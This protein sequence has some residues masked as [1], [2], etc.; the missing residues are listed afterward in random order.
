MR[1]F[2]IVRTEALTL[3]LNT[4]GRELASYGDLSY[5]DFSFN[6]FECEWQRKSWEI[7]GDE[8]HVPHFCS[9]GDWGCNITDVL[10]DSRLDNLSF[11]VEPEQSFL[12]RYYT[13]FMLL[14]VEMINDFVDILLLAELS[15]GTKTDRKNS[16][17]HAIADVNE[18]TNLINSL[19][20]HK[21]DKADGGHIHFHNH[22]LP[23]WFEDC[24]LA[25][26]FKAPIS[27]DKA[28][29]SAPDGIIVPSLVMLTQVI[30]DGYQ[31]IDTHFEADANRFTAFCKRH[32]KNYVD[33]V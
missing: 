23:V 29:Q 28:I 33:P 11:G 14:T 27:Q 16:L 30:I 20:K 19:C 9:L 3:W 17:S 18:L 25:H 10:L 22:H 8:W 1:P 6:N 12:Y 31:T 7:F 5:D 2:G 24:G 4:T 26:P 15:T 21:A 13:R 32:G